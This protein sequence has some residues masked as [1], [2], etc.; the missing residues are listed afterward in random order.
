MLVQWEYERVVDI[1]EQYPLLP[2]EETI[3]IA[4]QLRIKHPPLNAP[5]G[6]ETVMSTDFVITLKK[7]NE[8]INIARTVKPKSKLTNRVKQKFTIEQEYWRRRGVDWGVVTDAELD[9]VMIANMEFLFP[10]YF[11]DERDDLG[12]EALTIYINDY[13]ELLTANNFDVIKT[14][15]EFDKVN[16]W[17]EG[18]SLSFF[19][20]LIT[21]KI[22]NVDMKRRI[23]DFYKKDYKIWF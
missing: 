7:G 17:V 10:F 8:K 21:K 18:E 15:N 16:G 5:K 2:L 19:K 14:S 12:K 1:R 11:W 6:N 4:E 9:P 22:I 23:T 20:Y 3:Q 13:K